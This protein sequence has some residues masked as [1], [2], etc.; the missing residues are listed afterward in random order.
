MKNFGCKPQ[1]YAAVASDN[2]SYISS[3]EFMAASV[4]DVEWLN[5][6]LKTIQEERGK[7]N[8]VTFDKNVSFKLF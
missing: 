4:G 3:Y 5:E 7:E 2:R 8:A 1:S 6:T